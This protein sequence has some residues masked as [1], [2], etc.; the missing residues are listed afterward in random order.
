MIMHIVFETENDNQHMNLYTN[1]DSSEY[2]I[3]IY[4]GEGN[5]LLT[6]EIY[7]NIPDS[8]ISEYEKILLELY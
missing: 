1:S 6:E 3:G 7:S 5:E 8:I 2:Y 4:L